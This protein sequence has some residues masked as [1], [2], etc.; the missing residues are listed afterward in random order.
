MDLIEII[1]KGNKNKK[2]I[3][4]FY[5]SKIGIYRKNNYLYRHEICFYG[6]LN[7]YYIYYD[8]LFPNLIKYSKINTDNI[9]NINLNILSLYEYAKNKDIYYITSKVNKQYKYFF[10][11]NNQENCII[12]FFYAY[13]YRKKIIDLNFFKD[14]KILFTFNYIVLILFFYKENINNNEIF[15]ILF[16]NFYIK[17]IKD[18][19]K[20]FY[21]KDYDN[22]IN[23]KEL[24]LFLKEKGYV[25]EYY[26]V[27]VPYV[28]QNY[29]KIFKK[30][31]SDPEYIPF[32]NKM[33]KKIKPYDKIDINKIIDSYYKNKDENI[34]IKKKLKELKIKL[35]I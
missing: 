12:R 16:Y 18:E 20:Y 28:K 26:N 9:N 4:N 11:K 8:I 22:I 1:K 27:I 19:I 32:K 15:T 30:I 24:Y 21:D 25:N 29:K 6:V 31:L 33:L 3:Y 14:K 5:L 35:N 34:N 2:K 13:I 7:K 17:V 23:Y 10:I